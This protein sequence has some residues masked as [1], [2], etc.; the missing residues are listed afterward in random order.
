[1]MTFNEFD[2]YAR[3]GKQAAPDAKPAKSAKVDDAPP[4]TLAGLAI[5][6]WQHPQFHD[7]PIPVPAHGTPTTSALRAG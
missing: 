2:P 5:L 6:A 4:A 1:M 7:V 3:F